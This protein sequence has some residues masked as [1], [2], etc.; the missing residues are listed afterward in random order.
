LKK[1]FV[2]NLPPTA[3]ED[4][5]TTLFSQYGTV[6]AINIAKDLFSGA[7]KGFAFI[8]MEG[9]EARAAIEGLNGVSFENNT[10][11][12]KFEQPRTGRGGRR[13]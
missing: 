3:T 12:V 13:R 2:G 10:L 1:L 6:R 7:C 8:E 9:H 11:A 4:S 5:L